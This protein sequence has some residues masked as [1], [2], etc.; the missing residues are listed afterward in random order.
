MKSFEEI[1][2]KWKYLELKKTL[3]LVKTECIVVEGFLE[4]G[5]GAGNIYTS[6]RAQRRA[7]ESRPKGHRIL[8][9]FVT[10]KRKN[11]G[12]RSMVQ[13]IC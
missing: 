5:K 8:T 11:E 12:R 13:Q 10:G 7:K 9:N 4:G 3:N 6:W 2:G 1:W